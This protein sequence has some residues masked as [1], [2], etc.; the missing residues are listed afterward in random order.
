MIITCITNRKCD[1]S[2]KTLATLIYS[3]DIYNEFKIGKQYTVYGMSIYNNIVYYLITDIPMWFPADFFE[4]TSKLLYNEWYFEFYGNDVDELSALWGYKELLDPIHYQNLLEREPED[5]AIFRKRKQEID[6]YEAL[7]SY[8]PKKSANNSDAPALKSRVYVDEPVDQRICPESFVQFLEKYLQG[9]ISSQKFAQQFDRF[10]RQ[11][12]DFEELDNTQTL[13]IKKLVTVADEYAP[14][15]INPIRKYSS[16]EELTNA[17]Q[18]AFECVK[19]S[20]YLSSI[21]S[22]Y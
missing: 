4:I 17:A 9:R 15:I 2:Q 3:K 6:E 7:S 20:A 5:M 12:I 19:A 10:Y 21:E 22:E 8:I 11:R 1:L 18:E 16:E 14:D 13:I